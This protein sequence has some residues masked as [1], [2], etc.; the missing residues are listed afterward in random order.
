MLVLLIGCAISVRAEPR[1]RRPL[2]RLTKFIQPRADCADT[3][4]EEYDQFIASCK[5][6]EEFCA[7][8]TGAMCKAAWD[9]DSDSDS[10]KCSRKYCNAICWRHWFDLC[11]GLSKAAVIGIAVAAAVVVLIIVGVIVYCCC[12]RKKH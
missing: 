6:A 12:I 8:I 5:A 7:K 9:S 3:T 4:D 10:I 11:H 1:K 2:D